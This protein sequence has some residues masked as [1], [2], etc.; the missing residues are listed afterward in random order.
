MNSQGSE[1][2]REF[3]V[4]PKVVSQIWKKQKQNKCPKGDNNE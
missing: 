1:K 4:D 2:F 3:W